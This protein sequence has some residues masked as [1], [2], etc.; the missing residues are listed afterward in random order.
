MKKFRRA[1]IT[2][3]A[4]GL[5]SEFARQLAKSGAE[6]VLL[7]RDQAGLEALAKS[8]HGSAQ[9]IV[10]DLSDCEGLENILKREL[11][12]ARPVDLLV[13]NAGIDF[14]VHFTGASW[15]AARDHFSI[16]TL[17]NYVLMDALIPAMVA[18]GGGHVIV[19]ASLAALAPFPGEAPYCA[20][21]TAMAATIEC[22]RAELLPQGVGFT[23]AYPSFIKTPMIRGNRLKTVLAV[24]PAEAA[25]IILG[26]AR[27]GRLDVAF[28]TSASLGV[29]LLGALPAPLRA[30]VSRLLAKGNDAE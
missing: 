21:K 18:A 14:P 9:L 27:D 17:S 30:R 20:S 8:L 29:K 1:L 4:G 15:R 23:T 10:A 13:A 11:D 2:G 16:N 28:P 3:A 12:P 26:A 6:L 7:D 22:A 19:V 5:G 24:E 25:R